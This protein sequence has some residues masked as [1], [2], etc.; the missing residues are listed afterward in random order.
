MSEWDYCPDCGTEL[1]GDAE[2]CHSGGRSCPSRKTQRTIV[3]E[4]VRAVPEV[5]SRILMKLL[6]TV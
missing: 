3:K 6:W 1:V 2:F 5:L 4:V